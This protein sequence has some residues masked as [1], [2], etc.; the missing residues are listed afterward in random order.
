MAYIKQGWTILGRH[1]VILLLFFIYQWAWTFMLYRGIQGEVVPLLHRFPGEALSAQ[2]SQLF[3][4]EGQFQLLKTDAAHGVLWTLLAVLLL[5]MLLSPLLNAGL[6]YCIYHK[7]SG[8]QVNMWKGIKTCGKPFIFIYLIQTAINLAPVYWLV[9]HAVAAY[10]EAASYTDMLWSI[11]PWLLGYMI[12]VFIVKII[13]IH[14]QFGKV[15]EQRIFANAGTVMRALIPA[16]MISFL[17][18]LLAGFII[19]TTSAITMVWA[20]LISII[21][22]QLYQLIRT[23]LQI[24][25]ITS[26]YALWLT[27]RPTS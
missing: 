14:I 2:A 9:K 16:T 22:H 18:A 20:G 8:A 10:Q 26:Q 7:Q 5:R 13:F 12:Y 23:L 19:L 17:I 6:Y 1:P 25:E 27:K 11:V 4:A 15:S 24:W 3:L 21:L